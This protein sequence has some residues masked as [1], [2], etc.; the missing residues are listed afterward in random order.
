MDPVDEKSVGVVAAEGSRI[1]VPLLV[2]SS[3]FEV[4]GLAPVDEKGLYVV[5]MC[6][7]ASTCKAVAMSE[8]FPFPL[9]N[10]NPGLTTG[11]S[12]ELFFESDSPIL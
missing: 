11:V 9:P 10:E 5:G 6:L 8:G 4:S 12:D 1:V 2:S 7:D 3:F